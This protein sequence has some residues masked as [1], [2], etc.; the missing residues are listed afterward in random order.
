MRKRGRPIGA[1]IDDSTKLQ[2][3]AEM[4]RE[5]PD[6]SPT[7]ALRAIGEGHPSVIRRLRDKF[8]RAA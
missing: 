5:N 8:K 1:G 3:L 7:E 2:A 4:I 6:L